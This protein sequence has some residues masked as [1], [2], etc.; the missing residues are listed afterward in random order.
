MVEEKPVI[1]AAR[2]ARSTSV[3]VSTAATTITFAAMVICSAASSAQ[4]KTVS[5]S[6][7]TRTYRVS[8]NTVQAVVKS[9]KRNGPNSELH[10]RRARAMADYRVRTSVATQRSEGRCIVKGAKVSMRISYIVPKLTNS[11]RL[12]PGHLNRWR[13]IKSMIVRHE[14]QHGRYYRTFAHQ[15]QA[16]LASIR[17][18][19]SCSQVRVLEKKITKRLKAQS[20]RRNR[21]YDRGQYAPFNRRLKNLAPKR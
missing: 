15:L 16:A 19:Q 8:G 4:A 20:I 18:Q 11:S 17:P 7:H 10:G 5:I 13:K 1:G 14:N 6:E 9:M 12:S 3:K 21:N 2:T